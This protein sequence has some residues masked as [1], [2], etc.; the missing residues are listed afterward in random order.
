[1]IHSVT[2]TQ[3]DCCTVC[4]LESMIAT[5]CVRNRMLKLNT[6]TAT[7]CECYTV[8]QL[9]SVITTQCVRYRI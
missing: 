7:Q 6:V 9:Q 1:M 4:K 5:Q 2:A 3:W 8:C